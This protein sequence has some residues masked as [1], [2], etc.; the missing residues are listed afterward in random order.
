MNK[1]GLTLGLL[2]LIFTILTA[3]LVSADNAIED[4]AGRAEIRFLEGM[5]DHHQMALNMASDCLTKAETESVSNLCVSVIK[6]QSA[7]IAQMQEWLLNWYNIEYQPMSMTDM[8]DMMAGG[9]GG[10]NH[11]M[12]GTPDTDPAMMM[13]MMAG[14]N[15]LEGVQYETAWLESMID[16]HD[17]AIHMSERIMERVPEGGG[18]AEL[19]ALAQQIITD[20]TAEIETMEQIITGQSA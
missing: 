20:Q 8:M 10:M 1:R 13:G 2:T 5:I 14:F 11:N 16:H 12:A 9:M 7:E 17:D 4:R 15:R 6:A 18:H 3:S 19:R